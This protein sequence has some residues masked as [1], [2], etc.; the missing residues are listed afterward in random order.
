MLR[1]PFVVFFCAL[2]ALP[3][4]RAQISGGLEGKW[5]HYTVA[6]EAGESP[7][8][9]LWIEG[10]MVAWRMQAGV[11]A[12]DLDR[13]LV[14]RPG[15]VV[16]RPPADARVSTSEARPVAGPSLSAPS[17]LIVRDGVVTALVELRLTP[18]CAKRCG[19]A[20][21][22]VVELAGRIFAPDGAAGVELPA[23]GRF[24]VEAGDRRLSWR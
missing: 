16:S 7:L 14:W 23:G 2:F 24:P 6:A 12:A 5:Q 10:E 9:D 4:A 20:G 21:L 19:L 1:I 17:H 18:D 8:F 22:D 13:A 15:A 3:S 11:A